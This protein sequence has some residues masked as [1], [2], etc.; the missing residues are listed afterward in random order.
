M[1]VFHIKRKT[2]LHALSL[3][4]SA[5]HVIGFL[6]RNLHPKVSQESVSVVEIQIQQWEG[7]KER[8]KAQKGVLYDAF[9]SQQPFELTRDYATKLGCV[10]WE[11]SEKRFLFVKEESHPAMRDFIKG[12]K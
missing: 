10:L 7:E 1:V 9:S 11:N 6:R 4:L 2:I 8:I 5:T 12:L 3:G